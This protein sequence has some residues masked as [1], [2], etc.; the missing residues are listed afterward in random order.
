[1]EKTK[2]YPAMRFSSRIIRA[3]IYVCRQ[4][5]NGRDE[6]LTRL[7]V[8]NGEVQWNYDNIDE[9]LTEYS[10]ANFN[11]AWL[12]IF[13]LDMN[14][15]LAITVGENTNILVSSKNREHIEQVFSVFEEASDRDRVHIFP[16]LEIRIFIGHGRDDQWRKLKSHLQD[17]H[18]L[19]ILAYETGARAGHAI[20]DILEAMSDEASFALLVLTAEDRA[21]TGLR[22]RQNVVHEC[23]LFQGRL[24]FDRAILL[25]EEGVELASNF[26]GIQQLRFETG[27]ISEVFGDVIATLRREFGPI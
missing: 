26:D 2:R 4:Q 13:W 25:V 1:M 24:G 3:A 21:E 18:R 9:F 27:R 7:S 22:A 19:E 10:S 15:S 5:S 14:S 20:R 17:K 11:G 8:S 23:G 16:N 12:Q 6:R